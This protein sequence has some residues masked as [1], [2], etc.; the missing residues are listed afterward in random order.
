MLRY[1]LVISIRSS[2]HQND[3]ILWRVNLVELQLGRRTSQ[4][5]HDVV[6]YCGHAELSVEQYA[7]NLQLGK[8]FR[9]H[10]CDEFQFMRDVSSEQQVGIIDVI[11]D[12]HLIGPP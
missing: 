10:I 8:L 3:A 9:F 7:M 5:T 1:E 2:A 11:G 4:A 6:W 12:R